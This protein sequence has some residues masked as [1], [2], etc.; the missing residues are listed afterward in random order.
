MSNRTF[1]GVLL[2]FAG[3]IL[4]V[5]NLELLDTHLSLWSALLVLTGLLVVYGALTG[6]RG[7]DWFSLA[8]GLWLGSMGV[9]EMLS[10]AG[11][12]PGRDAW[13]VAWTGWPVLLIGAGVEILIRRGGTRS[14]DQ[15]PGSRGLGREPRAPEGDPESPP[16][17]GDAGRG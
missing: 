9:F 12:T 8:L 14:A 6:R 15:A 5:E 17:H 2:V 7:V 10:D 13:W 11:V 4:L 16:H 3:L 1:W